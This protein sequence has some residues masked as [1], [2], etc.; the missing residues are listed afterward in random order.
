MEAPLPPEAAAIFQDFFTQADA[1]KDGLLN[2]EEYQKFLD[3]IADFQQKQFNGCAPL[4]PDEQEGYYNLMN[5]YNPHVDGIDLWSINNS[6]KVYAAIKK[7]TP[8]YRIWYFDGYG[9]AEPIRLLLTHAN[10]SWED[11]PIP[12]KDWYHPEGKLKASMPGNGLPQLIG[13]DD[14]KKGGAT[15][16]TVRYLALKYGYYPDDPMRA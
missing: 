3:I 11:W 12:F 4:S 14:V 16:A 5:T 6:G 10:V 2:C 13:K 8:E 7:N 15:R 9:R 1:N